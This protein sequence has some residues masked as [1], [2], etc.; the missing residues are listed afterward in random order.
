MRGRETMSGRRIHG[1]ILGAALAAAVLLFAAGSAQALQFTPHSLEGTFNGSTSP[2]GPFG[3]VS[4]VAVDQQSGDVYVLTNQNGLSL[5]K[6]N[7]QGVPTPFTDPSLEGSSVITF[8]INGADL[9]G[10]NRPEVRVD[11]SGGPDQGRIYVEHNFI[12]NF[13]WALEPTGAMVGGHYPLKEAPEN[14]AVSPLNGN[15]FMTGLPLSQRAY[16]FSPEGVKTGKVIDLSQY[17]YSYELDVGPQDELF[18]FQNEHGI[19]KFNASGEYVESL[20]NGYSTVFGVDPVSGHLFSAREERAAEFDTH[21]DEL[22]HF[23]YEGEP[24]SI[25]INGINHYIYL[26][27]GGNVDVFAPE[28]PVTIPEANTE[29]PTNIQAHSVTLNASVNPESVATNE[30]VFEYGTAV[31][32]GTILYGEST[33][34]EQGQSIS[35]SSPSSVSATISGLSQGGKYHY[36]LSVGNSNGTFRTRDATVIPSEKPLVESPY[37]TEVHSDSVVFHAE[38]TPEG[39][40]TTFHV[41]YGTA[42]CETDPGACS[43]T[44][45]TASVGAGLVPTPVTEKLTGLEAGTTYHYTIVATNQSGSTK[46]TDETFTTFP[47]TP[48]LE[49]KCA[50][51]HVRQQTGAALLADCRAYELVSAANAGGYDVESYLNAEQE[52]FAGYPYAESPPRVLYGVHDGA[53]PGSGHPTN[54]GLDPYIATRGAN[55]WSTSYVGIPANLP[56]SAEAF[57]SPL[58]G[59]DSSLDTFAFGGP[60]LCS[61]CFADGS[62]GVPVALPNGSLV[63][64]MAGTLR[65]G[66][67]RHRQ[68]ACE[69]TAL[70]RRPAPDLWLRL[71][72]RVRRRQ[73][74]DL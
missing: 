67:R 52:P 23:S 65:A 36:R 61:P 39:A 10:C 41:L 21:G 40:P 4:T 15:L 19:M 37:V 28:A 74:G 56:Y 54:H 69:E 20:P 71:R 2:G 12:E 72:I 73:S 64:G 32:Y 58:A 43:E 3:E 57:A 46:S 7:A 5:Y 11:N 42:D 45:E 50:N 53:I 24:S 34:C 27:I 18:D 44:A 31:S 62:T 13:V 68:H 6:F 38:I 9:C 55:G 35:G 17:G 60:G 63:Q 29:A 1:V 8:G 26:G 48:V 14:L 59:A 25:A 30:C 66:C 49:D 51:A 16:E 47:Y 33:P 22:P 70:R